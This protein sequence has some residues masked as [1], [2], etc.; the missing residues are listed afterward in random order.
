VFGPKGEIIT[1]ARRK[2][3]NKEIHNLYS[4][5]NIIRVESDIWWKFADS[6]EDGTS[7]IFRVEE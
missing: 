5:Q 3:Y 7:A 1:K 6:S 4:S 2:L